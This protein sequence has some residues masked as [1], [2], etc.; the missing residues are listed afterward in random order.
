[1]VDR[2]SN[3]SLDATE[4]DLRELFR[5]FGHTLSIFLVK[6]RQ[7][8]KSRGFAFVRFLDKSDAE[9]AIATLHRHRYDNL[10]LEV[11]W[12]APRGP[13]PDGGGGSFSFRGRGRGRQS[14]APH[15]RPLKL[16][17]RSKVRPPSQPIAPS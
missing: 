11:E 5:R 15:R 17:P 10:I 6:D 3:L 9:A 8:Y 7:T 16:L 1:M 13:R 4:D 12:A 14:S 2:V